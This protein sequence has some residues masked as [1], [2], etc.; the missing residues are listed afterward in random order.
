MSDPLVE[1]NYTSHV[2]AEAFFASGA[3]RCRLPEMLDFSE[4]EARTSEGSRKVRNELKSFLLSSLQLQHLLVL[5][6]SGTSLECGGPSVK[7]LWEAVSVIDGFADVCDTVNYHPEPRSENIEE[8][9][10]RCDAQL[11]LRDDSTTRAFHSKA[12]A[13]ILELCRQAGRDPKGLTAHK[14]FLRRLSR[15]RARDSRL[16]L[17]T[18]NY[19]KC[20]E[21]A[22]G[23]VGLVPID[24]FS[25][26]QPR[27]FDPRFFEY[28]IGR[29]GAGSDMLT[30]VPG[31]FQ[32]FKLHGSVD[33]AARAGRLEI[34]DA[35]RPS[36][37]C[38]IYP[39]RAKFQRSYEQP[40][41]EL[42]AQYLAALRE[43]NTCLVTAGFGFGDA[44]LSAP[45][46][47]ALETN[48]HFRLVVVDPQVE[49]HL[50]N[51]G[52]HWKHLDELAVNSDV[53]FVAASFA[54]FANLIP[55]LL[56]LTPAEEVVR[57][58]RG[59]TRGP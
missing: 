24:G 32:Y 55:D 17:F 29:R 50:K 40:H 15:R 35:V 27:R 21:L 36:E 34:D 43:P 9:L 3:A 53:G 19:D 49:S 45:I 23:E 37:A 6:G 54:T 5:A 47:A 10:S 48:P 44:H 30:P 28:D 33:W 59:V 1:S 14:E 46:L 39:A 8:L 20:F 12:V 25:Y 4:I 2:G 58:I 51:G 42:M 57:S 16:K 56:A 38:L 22:S 7:S 11:E 26:S 13:R 41:L 52:Q 31:V 18:T